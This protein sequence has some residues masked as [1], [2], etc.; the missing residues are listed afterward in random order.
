[1]RAARPIEKR[2]VLVGAGN[3]HLVFL[4]RWRMRPMP[5]VAVTLVSDADEVP[6]SAMVPGVVGGD[7]A[8][9]EAMIDLVRLCAASGVR[10]LAQRAERLDPVSRLV[11]FQGR[12]PLGYD[13]LS[14]G[15]G[16]MPPI[17]P[18]CGETALTLRPLDRLMD[19]LDSLGPCRF[20]VIGGG[21]SGCELALALKKRVPG[22]AVTLFQHADRLVPRMPGRAGRFFQQALE[23]AGIEVRLG[24]RVAGGGPGF[25]ELD[26]GERV[27][28]DASLWA[29]SAGPPGLLRDS[30]LALDATGFLRVRATLQSV[31]DPAVFGTG[32]CVAFDE[33]PWLER[34]GVHAVRQG[35]VLFDNVARFLHER[36]L[37]R[38]R[39][40]WF[41]LS[42]LNTADGDAL[43]TWGAFATKGRWMRRW[44][45]R[46]DR[47]WMRMM[48]EFPAMK[49]EGGKEAP[50]MRCGGCGNKIPGDVLGAAVSRLDI[51]D[52]PR[53]LAGAKAGED[54]AVFRSAGGKLEVQ[55]VD[56]FK[57]FTDDPYLFGRVAALHSL[58]DLYAMNAEPFA[59]LAVATLPHARG[60]VQ[61]ER[62]HEMLAGAA[63]E[64][65]RLGVV[66][67]GGHT[68]EGEAMALGFS[69]TGHADEGRLFRK[70]RLKV[71]D[72]LV[73]TKPVG[74]GAILAAWM[75]GA[76]KAAWF[77][78]AAEGMLLPN[79][80]AGAVFAQAG[81]VACTD[82]TGFGLAGHLLE[83]IRPSRV[84]AVLRDVPRY[85]GFD[86]VAASG[87]VST[88]H[89]GNARIGCRIEGPTPA[90]LFD[91]QT[92]GGLIAGVRPERVEEVL[93]AVPT[94]RV[95]GEVVPM[96]D[97]P[98]IRV[99]EA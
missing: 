57:A 86:E 31:S 37:K 13:A 62:L 55:T 92:S 22:I 21:A 91:P 24:A 93:R 98:T 8:R 4:S 48:T 28:A 25:L 97:A 6:Y 46:L 58:S 65:K 64:L 66:L 81:V 11:H 36:G 34:N 99:E 77:R 73:L 72:K 3:A 70:G 9:S 53:V 10:L 56:Y 33:F 82:I 75:R 61:E 85:P 60:P 51:H 29:T 76:C 88:L 27:G 17:P 39:P 49:A 94:A 47:R 15:L 74:T 59:A 90:W 69:V 5:G 32:D 23:A 80:D 41:C 19:R 50:L 71:G 16:S 1:M 87:I 89:E 2:V 79:K 54:A 20:A 30:G 44:K 67:A 78:A 96:G 83:M 40:Q 26:G 18:G 42:L 12:P 14:L 7:Y 43:A 52:D 45:D 38:Y 68:T 95:V 35:R 84:S 63:L